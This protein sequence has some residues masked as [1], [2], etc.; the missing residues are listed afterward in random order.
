MALEQ[1]SLSTPTSQRRQNIIRLLLLLIGILAK[2]IFCY[3]YFLLEWDS[4]QQVIAAK[5]LLGGHG[6]TNEIVTIADLSSKIYKPLT[7][8]P[9]AYSYLIAA[10]YTIV[11]D[12]FISC[13]LAN[14]LFS[15]LFIFSIH[16]LLGFLNVKF[17]I[18]N[19]IILYWGFALT[20]D[21][22]HSSDTDLWGAACCLIAIWMCLKIS[23]QKNYKLSNAILLGLLAAA[24]AFIKYMFIPCSF[25]I[26]GLILL[27]ALK[28][29]NKS[30]L[31]FGWQ[32]SCAA[33][34][35]VVML[36]IFY[37]VST[38]NSLFS[39]HLLPPQT[40]FFPENLKMFDPFFVKAVADIHFLSVQLEKIAHL[41]Y[42][43]SMRF[44]Q[45]LNVL[46]AL[47]L[48]AALFFW[49]KNWS[50]SL[51]S[52]VTQF[53]CLSITYTLALLALFSV[54]SLTHYSR[55]T[56]TWV[57]TYVWESRYYLL[58]KVL[59]TIFVGLAVQARTLTPRPI[60]LA[61]GV[62]MILMVVTL[63]HNIYFFT[64]TVYN[65]KHID[66]E[67]NITE[68]DDRL[69]KKLISKYRDQQMN[70]AVASNLF[71]FSLRGTLYDANAMIHWNSLNTQEPKASTRSRLIVLIRDIDRHLLE[72]YI[73][74]HALTF[75]GRVDTTN[76][77]SMEVSAD[78]DIR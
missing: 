16:K 64:K 44:A 71:Q 34:G 41:P 25:I 69:L 18:G 9:P 76:Y 72:S 24:P 27:T 13:H 35:A 48:C 21:I 70:V 55:L 45:P 38:R 5:N 30:L 29:K 22:T 77:Y 32:V 39:D 43:V 47:S 28:T 26:P 33:V 3:Y 52:P 63:T 8:W 50:I 17:W 62:A 66:Q 1:L 61:A 46:I 57:W 40:G 54:L 10:L 53:V 37:G 74:R 65:D 42:A 75:E 19:V 51:S 58:P 31:I 12:W 14:L 59:F 23:K 7:G 68:T 67:T 11:R 36:L 20:E 6:L 49:R 60:K 56:V 78:E 2:T 73:E 15:A 4:Q